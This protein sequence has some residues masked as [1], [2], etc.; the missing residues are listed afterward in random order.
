MNIVLWC[1][2]LKV[3]HSAFA[4]A[5]SMPCSAP[6]LSLV[7]ETLQ[8]N[9]FQSIRKALLQLSISLCKRFIFFLKKKIKSGK[10]A[11][12]RISISLWRPLAA[13]QGHNIHHIPPGKGV[14]AFGFF[15][16][17]SLCPAASP[18]DDG[19][20]GGVGGG[21]GGVL[22]MR[23]KKITRRRRRW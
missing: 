15:H 3:F 18:L 9:T 20:G 19:G 10:N 12:P 21:G 1:L 11:T 2:F 4:G 23:G 8:E 6:N 7:L 14:G 5:M 22:S 16:H 13:P 17:L